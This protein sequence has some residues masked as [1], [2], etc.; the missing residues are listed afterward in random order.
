MFRTENCLIV[1]QMM[2]TESFLVI[3]VE[4]GVNRTIS[5]VND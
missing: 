1:S 3:Q 5:E 4:N 2:N